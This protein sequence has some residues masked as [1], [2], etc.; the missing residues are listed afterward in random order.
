M[1]SRDGAERPVISAY[2]VV[3]AG[4]QPGPCYKVPVF[5]ALVAIAIVLLFAGL[6]DA[7]T[8]RRR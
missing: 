5:G 4:D 7:L 3:D 1:P 8:D 6:S 2:S